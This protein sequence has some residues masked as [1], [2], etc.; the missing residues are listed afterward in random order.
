MGSKA[1]VLILCSFLF[2]ISPCKVFSGQPEL[3]TKTVN[4]SE[5]SQVT[6]SSA[7]VEDEYDGMVV[8]VDHQKGALG[9]QLDADSLESHK[10]KAP[11]GKMAF[12][13][14]LKE[15]GFTNSMNRELEFDDIK[16]GHSVTVYTTIGKDGIEKVVDVWDYN[17]IPK[18]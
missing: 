2:A 12:M 3:T 16:V 5:K 7:A 17:G 10:G 4:V 11:E 1:A 14:D 6:P 15:T 8:L 9:I 13:V 18:E